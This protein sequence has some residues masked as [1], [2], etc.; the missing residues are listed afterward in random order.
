MKSFFTFLLVLFFTLQLSAQKRKFLST[1]K[2]QK[3]FD[4]A[5]DLYD[6]GKFE[7][8]MKQFKKLEVDFPTEPI[9]LY[10]IGVC[11]LYEKGNRETAYEYLSKVDKSKFSKSD[12]LYRLAQAQALVGKY[13]EAK[14]NATEALTKKLD[15][16]KLLEV[17]LLLKQIEVAK[18]IS[19][20]AAYT[21]SNAGNTIN[22]KFDETQPAINAAGNYLLF[23][24]TGEKS[25]GGLQAQPGDKNADGVFFTDIYLSKKGT[26]GSWSN[27]KVYDSLL[28]TNGSEYPLSIAADEKRMLSGKQESYT[29]YSI[30]VNRKDSSSWTLL[31]ELSGLINTIGY[32]G[33]A[34]LFPSNTKIIFSSDRA[35]GFGGKDLYTAELMEDSTWGKVKNLGQGINSTYDED[36]PHMHVDGKTLHFSSNGPQSMGGYDIFTAEYSPEEDTWGSKTNLG[37]PVNTSHDELQFQVLANGKMAYFSS[38]RLGGLGGSDIYMVNGLPYK[39]DPEFEKREAEKLA[40]IQKRTDDSIA[41]VKVKEIEAQ[42]AAL[43]KSQTVDNTKTT[44]GNDAL[45]AQKTAREEA[46]LATLAKANEEKV[47]KMEVK[48]IA[49]ENAKAEK[50]AKRAEMIAKQEA[51]KLAKEEAM[52]EKNANTNNINNAVIWDWSKYDLSTESAIAAEFGDINVNNLVYKVQIASGTLPESIN[53]TIN[54]DLGQIEEI[55]VKGGKKYVIEKSFSTINEAFQ[56]KN[57]AIDKGISDAFITGFYNGKRIYLIDLVKKGILRK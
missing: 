35:G 27:S 39:S 40:A 38:G 37:T 57:K 32:E 17:A 4:L 6:E 46:R 10:R 30:S 16:K 23:A 5:Q 21:V 8:A 52:A 53:N 14:L 48:R 19:N 34:A 47:A 11:Q 42:Q 31:G 22:T 7:F 12:F 13:D 36:F 18:A 43:A 50:E 29:N 56:L 33:G 9:L 55:K 20:N 45:A 49:A 41:I 24:Y 51:A 26:D 44:I 2:D 28:A 1:L 54:S 25:F 15:S 3:T